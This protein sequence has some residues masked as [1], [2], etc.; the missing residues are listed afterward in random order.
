M[1]PH[2]HAHGDTQLKERP[3]LVEVAHS[4]RRW[5][6]YHAGWTDVRRLA[7][8]LVTRGKLLVTNSS[9]APAANLCAFPAAS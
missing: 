3:C 1:L 5:G 2:K 8:E 7:I 9:D 4:R 6:N